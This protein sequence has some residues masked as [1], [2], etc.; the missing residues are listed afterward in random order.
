MVLGYAFLIG[1]IAQIYTFM[2]VDKTIKHD[3]LWYGAH[4]KPRLSYYCVKYIGMAFLLLNLIGGLYEEAIAPWTSSHAVRWGWF[5]SVVIFALCAS[6]KTKLATSTL[7][8]EN[9]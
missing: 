4:K 3:N 9:L 5:L 7:F 8:Q 6:R 1:G 2:I